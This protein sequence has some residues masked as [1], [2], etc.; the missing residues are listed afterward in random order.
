MVSS[1]WD[2]GFC[3]NFDEMSGFRAEGHRATWADVEQ[4]LGGIARI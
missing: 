4:W 1:F 2:D 3:V